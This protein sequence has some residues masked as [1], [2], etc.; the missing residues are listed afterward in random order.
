[1]KKGVNILPSLINLG[2]VNVNTPQQNSSVFIGESLITGMDGN[3]KYNAGRAGQYGFFCAYLGSIS[4]NIDSMEVVD[5][6]I[7]DTDFKLNTAG[8]NF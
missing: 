4:Q 5:G 6:I 1:M 3:M 7:Y 2:V 8:S